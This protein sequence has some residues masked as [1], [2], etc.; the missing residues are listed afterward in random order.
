MADA[1]VGSVFSRL[2]TYVPN[3]NAKNSVLNGLNAINEIIGRDKLCAI[4]IAARVLINI[5]P[6]KGVSL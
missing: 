4:R 5:V 2:T 3:G 6:L 1:V